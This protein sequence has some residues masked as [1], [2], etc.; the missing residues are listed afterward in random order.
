MY[1]PQNL[2]VLYMLSTKHCSV[3]ILMYMN[4]VTIL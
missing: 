3:Y 4:D 2:Y 1:I